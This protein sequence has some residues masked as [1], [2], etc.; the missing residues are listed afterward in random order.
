MKY[1]IGF[2][3]YRCPFEICSKTK[4]S[5]IDLLKTINASINHKPTCVAL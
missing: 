3:Y 1:F 4:A 5:F 2:A